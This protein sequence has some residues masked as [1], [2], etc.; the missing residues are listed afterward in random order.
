[1]KHEE[2]IKRID[3][4][5]DLN[6]TRIE[7]IRN[8]QTNIF[9]KYYLRD[10]NYLLDKTKTELLNCDKEYER[11]AED[12]WG[13]ARKIIQLENVGG[14]SAFEIGEIFECVSSYAVIRDN[15]TYKEA[16]AKV[17]TYEQK[18]KEESEKPVIGDIVVHDFTKDKFVVTNFKNGFITGI[19]E[20]FIKHTYIYPNEYIKKTGKHFDIQGMLDEIK[21]ED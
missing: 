5:I 19:D 18:K 3:E 8:D 14:Y 21:T 10:A 13:L 9:E 11:G 16:I 4:Q 17:E 15:K 12:A 6:K 20:R 1:M 2:L 7:R